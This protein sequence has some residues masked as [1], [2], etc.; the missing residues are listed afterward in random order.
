MLF[1]F[2]QQKNSHNT[3]KR[4]NSTYISL[5]PKSKQNIHTPKKSIIDDDFHDHSEHLNMLSSIEFL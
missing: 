3:M 2:A 5:R 4:S 1:Y